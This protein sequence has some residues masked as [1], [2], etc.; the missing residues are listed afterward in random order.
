MP[1]CHF[2]LTGSPKLAI[3]GVIDYRLALSMANFGVK[4]F[5]L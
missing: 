3:M 5:S 2:D 1:V 4:M